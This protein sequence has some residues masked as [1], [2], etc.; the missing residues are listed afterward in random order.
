VRALAAALLA[1]GSAAAQAAPGRVAGEDWRTF[2]G[3]EEL[4]R[5]RLF[6]WF[7][8]QAAAFGDVHRHVRLVPDPTF[9]RVVRVTQPA[10]GDGPGPSPR[11]RRSLPQPLDRMWFR[12]RMRFSPGWTTVGPSPP[13]ANAYKIAFWTWEAHDARGGLEFTNTDQYAPTWGV[14][15][16]AT[17]RGLGHTVAPLPGSRD[18]GRVTTEWTDGEWWEFVVLYERTGD[19]AGRQHLWR[20]RLTRGGQVDPGGWAY[21]GVAIS[22]APM[23]RV[24]AVELGANKN[25]STPH[26]QHIDWG[27]W[28]VVDGARSRDPFGVPFPQA[29]SRAP[30]A[31]PQR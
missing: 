9:G 7:Q 25:R 19:S 22:G 26:A 5:A 2:A 24:A 28:E 15:D 4:R 18:F 6:W 8:D 31:N 16:R 3:V 17:G 30:S 1:A 29:P 14:R 21:H 13:A 12:W 10:N 20:R 27:P 11:M 23:P